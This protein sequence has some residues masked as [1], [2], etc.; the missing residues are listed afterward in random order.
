MNTMD[1]MFPSLYYPQRYFLQYLY[2]TSV[3]KQSDEVIIT[4]FVV[5]ADNTDNLSASKIFGK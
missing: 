4:V 1:Q 2:C 3:K 5:D